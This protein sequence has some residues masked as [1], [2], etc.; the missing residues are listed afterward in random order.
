LAERE[1]GRILERQQVKGT[2]TPFWSISRRCN[3]RIHCIKTRRIRCDIKFLF[4]LG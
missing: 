2:E 3:K 4:H 1:G